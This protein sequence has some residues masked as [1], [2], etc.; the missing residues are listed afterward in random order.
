[1]SSAIVL[2][3]ISVVTSTQF[4]EGFFQHPA[5]CRDFVLSTDGLQ[6]FGRLTG[7]ACLPYDFANSVASD[8][9]VQ[10][11]RTMT[12]VATGETL[13]HLGELVKD[14]LSETRF[15]WES[16]DEA[17][18]LLPFVDLSCACSVYYP[19]VYFL[20]LSMLRS[21]TGATRESAIQKSCHATH[22]HYTSFRRVCNDWPVT[23]QS[24]HW[25]SANSDEQ[26]ASE[27]FD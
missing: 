10:V 20:T 3:L 19:V 17:S 7:L 16:I 4:L 5:H 9:M 23:R 18:R 14:S 24:S 13:L 26:H 12:E 11:L 25:P 21:P 15:F 6:R 1:M 8:S 27:R 2:S 22:P